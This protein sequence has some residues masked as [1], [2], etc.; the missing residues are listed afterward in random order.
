MSD[1]LQEDLIKLDGLALRVGLQSLIYREAVTASSP[2]LPL[3]GYVG[4][5]SVTRLNAIGLETR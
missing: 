2:T 4:K 3:G 5:S 1:K